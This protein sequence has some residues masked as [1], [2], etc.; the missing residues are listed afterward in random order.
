MYVFLRFITWF[1]L[2][3]VADEEEVDGNG[4][5][6]NGDGCQRLG[7]AEPEEEVQQ[8]YVQEVVHQVG[9]AETESLAPRRTGAEGEASGEV[10]VGEETED[11]ARSVGDVDVED[12]LKQEEESVVQGCGK[13]ADHDEPYEFGEFVE[14]LHLLHFS[15][16]A[17]VG[18]VI[19]LFVLLRAQTY[20]QATE[21]V[22]R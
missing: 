14:W 9:T 10:E 3:Y 2:E 22:R 1:S 18:N 11:V 21:K 4:D 7:H 12:K 16:G 6:E 8:R 19:D 15:I 13:G 17:K 5:G 20:L